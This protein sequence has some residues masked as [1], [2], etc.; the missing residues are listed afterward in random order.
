MAKARQKI[1]VDFYHCLYQEANSSYE[2]G[3]HE[4]AKLIQ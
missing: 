2:Y 3:K 1:A 4:L